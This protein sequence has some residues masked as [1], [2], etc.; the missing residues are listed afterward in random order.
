MAH[1]PGLFYQSVS[2]P[3]LT[4][5]FDGHDVGKGGRVMGQKQEGRAFI[6][7]VLL[8]TRMWRI[9]LRGISGEEDEVEARDGREVVI[10]QG[11]KFLYPDKKM[12]CIIIHGF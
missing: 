12:T 6:L 7:F 8:T 4:T 2:L 1:L 3:R 5:V 11:D 9:W 10:R